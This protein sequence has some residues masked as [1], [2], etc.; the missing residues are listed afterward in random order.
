[1]IDLDQMRA[2]D[3]HTHAEVAA[4]GHDPMPPDLREAARSYFRSHDAGLPTAALCGEPFPLPRGPE[5]RVPV[6]RR[7]SI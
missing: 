4:D 2:I 1:M 7:A 5:R 6:R 3:V